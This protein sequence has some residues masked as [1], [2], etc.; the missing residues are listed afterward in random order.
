MSP[1]SLVDA[2]A[3]AVAALVVSPADIIVLGKIIAPYGVQGAVRVHPFADDPSG[4]SK[5]THWWLAREGDAPAIWQQT[6]LIRSR[7]HNGV[8]IAELAGVADRTAAEALGGV[9]VAV[10]RAALPPTAADEYYW[11]DL[12]G[13]DVL[14][15]R[16]EPLGRILG[17]LDTPANAVMRVG[18]GDNGERLLPFV[19]AVVLEV[20][21]P[22]RCVRVEWELD[23]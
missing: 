10:P 11:A 17:L 14:N 22:G 12:V 3:A 5:L 8:L 15:S 23:W 21:L 4:W 20:D 13:L 18:D 9:L 2:A 7:L 1:A 19:A 16:D 6:R